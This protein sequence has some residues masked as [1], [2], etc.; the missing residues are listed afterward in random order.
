[1]GFVNS[2]KLISIVSNVKKR[3]IKFYNLLLNRSYETFE[4]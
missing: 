1:M 2:L 4:Y 3:N